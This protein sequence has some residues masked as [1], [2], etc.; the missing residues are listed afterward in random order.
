MEGRRA[1]LLCWYPCVFTMFDTG[2]D[3]SGQAGEIAWLGKAS[4]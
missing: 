1:E 4:Q 2:I 3:S